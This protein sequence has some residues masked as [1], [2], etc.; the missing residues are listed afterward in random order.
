MVAP[1]NA[2][3]ECPDGNDLLSVPSGRRSWMKCYNEYVTPEDITYEAAAFTARR[4]H[5]LA[6][7]T[8]Q[9]FKANTEAIGTNLR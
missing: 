1:A 5:E 9:A 8:P 7:S 3:A 4:F 6:L 2:A